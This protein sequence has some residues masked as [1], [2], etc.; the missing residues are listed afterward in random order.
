MPVCITGMHRS[1][2]SLVANLLRLCGLYLGEE[3]DLLP[4]TVDNTEGYWENRKFML[5]NDEI[6]RAL[7]GAWDFPPAPA[8]D[9]W[10]YDEKSNA[11]RLKAEVLLDEFA[12]REPWGWKD[13]R[14]CLTLPFWSRLIGMT[15][16]FWY[17]S[18]AKL[19]VVLCVR[20]PSE[21]S[22]SLR[23]RQYVPS[24]AGLPLW[25]I[26]N[27]RVL[28]VT[29]PEDRIVTHYEGYFHDP[30]LELR[31]VLGFLEMPASDEVIER[32]VVVV[33]DKLRHYRNRA[34]DLSDEAIDTEVLNLYRDLC[35]EA[36]YLEPL[37]VSI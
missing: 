34:D 31:R 14:N 24:S 5:L 26:Y 20:H 37:G 7:G 19:R 3:D 18:G 30:R 13:P 28:N 4:A 9:G 8:L 23:R 22:R 10:P 27:E 1:G 16:P 15:I 21:V 12:N 6:L 17:G 36:H 11:L 2:T 25:R 35:E 33:S 29:L 32:A